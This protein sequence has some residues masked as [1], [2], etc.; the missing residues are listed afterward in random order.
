MIYIYIHYF[1]I[2]GAVLY[3]V[4]RTGSR[5]PKNYY[6]YYYYFISCLYCGAQYIV[7]CAFRDPGCTM[8]TILYSTYLV[9]SGEMTTPCPEAGGGGGVCGKCI[10]QID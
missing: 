8:L 1:S 2:L 7:L 4:Y 3:L 6:Y 5:V 9:Y 10:V